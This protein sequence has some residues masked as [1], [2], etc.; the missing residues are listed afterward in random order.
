MQI[1]FDGYFF[2][3]EAK[4]RNVNYMT[5]NTRGFCRVKYA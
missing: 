4:H 3:K 5:I 2:L 1:K